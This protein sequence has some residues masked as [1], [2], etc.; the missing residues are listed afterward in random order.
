[1]NVTTYVFQLSEVELSSI[2]GLLWRYYLKYLWY[3][4]SNS[5]VGRI[6]YSS[7]IFALLIVLPLIILGLL[8]IASYGIARTLGVVDDVKA[9][10]S[11]K[12]T[13]HITNDTPAIR[14]HGP[15]SP[16]SDSTYTDSE[17]ESTIMDHTLHNRRSVLHD[18]APYES[19]DSLNV[20]SPPHVYYTEESNL[21]L[22]GVGMFSPAA[23]EPASPTISRRHLHN[24]APFGGIEEEELRQRTK[25]TVK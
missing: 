13:I 11:D 3:Y 24:D 16:D 17:R 9:S 5:W 21:K 15:S 23:S 1:M 12:S 25:H 22:S 20:T 19:N 2:P 4:D 14:V 8:D 10:T 18:A 6:A 7:R